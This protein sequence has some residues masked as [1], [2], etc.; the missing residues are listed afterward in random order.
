M[1]LG[2]PVKYEADEG[3][4]RAFLVETFSG[5]LNCGSCGEGEEKSMGGAAMGVGDRDSSVARSC[6]EVCI[7][8]MLR[9]CFGSCR[10]RIERES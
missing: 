4:I 2:K 3:T 5:G 10:L 1:L 7:R 6:E 9:V 8:R